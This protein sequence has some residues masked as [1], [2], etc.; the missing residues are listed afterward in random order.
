MIKEKDIYTI[1]HINALYQLPDAIM[2]LL[3][4]DLQK[5][6]EVY[7]VLLKSADYDVSYDWFQKIYESALA[8]RKTLKQDYTPNSI[9]RILAGITNNK[10]GRTHEP[11]AGTGGLIIA[12]W[13]TKCL[14]HT[15]FDFF[16]SEN[17][18]MA[19]ELSDQA[20]PFLLLNLSIR[21]I[22]GEIYHGDVLTREIK[23]KYILLNRNDDGLAF[24][25][26]IK[27]NNN[28]KIYRKI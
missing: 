1:L 17:Q 14:R 15:P 9:G 28:D 6:D 13:W 5:R 24:S 23:Q 22:M 19:W 10:D 18:V 8:Q 3:F 27:V 25:E 16:P 7:R 12:E 21:G 26:V 11:T 2:S 4:G 20:I